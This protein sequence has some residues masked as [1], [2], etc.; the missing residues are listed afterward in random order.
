MS[1]IGIR[2]DEL[3]AEERDELATLLQDP[4]ARAEHEEALALAAVLGSLQD[5]PEGP[6]AAE[7]LA[8]ARSRAEEA[9]PSPSNN[10]R[11]FWA[12]PIA[13][14]AAAALV[15]GTWTTEPEQRTKGNGNLT[16]V[17]EFPGLSAAA[18]VTETYYDWRNRPA[19]WLATVTP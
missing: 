16:S 3:T 12:L 2:E 6:S 11:W 5:A 10:T 19:T 1:L 13:A 7:V 4:E 18:R 14:A 9:T 8:R 15:V 17:T